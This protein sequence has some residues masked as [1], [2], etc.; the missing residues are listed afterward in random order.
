V[1]RPFAVTVICSHPGTLATRFPEEA[2]V[3]VLYRGDDVGMID[4]EM[5]ASIVAAVDGRSSLV[6][7]DGDGFRLAAARE[8]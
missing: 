8:P 5:A 7:V 3:R 2:T 6:W 4:D 1:S